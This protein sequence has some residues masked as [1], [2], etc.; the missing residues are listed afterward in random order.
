MGKEEGTDTVKPRWGLL[1]GHKLAPRWLD[2]QQA[3]R[4][5]H[6]VFTKSTKLVHQRLKS[7]ET[8]HKNPDFSED[9]GPWA[10]I[11]ATPAPPGAGRTQVSFVHEFEGTAQTTGRQMPWVSS[12]SYVCL[13][14]AFWAPAAAS[15]VRATTNA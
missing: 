8:S 6:A 3:F 15:W 2:I 1:R 13:A 10:R 4:L 5:A 7:L 9:L 11:P 12:R 14:Y